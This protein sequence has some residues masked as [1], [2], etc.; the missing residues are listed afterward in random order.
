LLKSINIKETAFISIV[1]PC[2]NEEQ[3]IGDCLNSIIANDYPGDH[4]EVLVIDG[5]SEDGTR[6]IGNKKENLKKK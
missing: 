1:I 3:F 2:R 5:M 6:E 4:L